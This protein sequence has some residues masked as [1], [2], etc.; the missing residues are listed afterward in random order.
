MVFDAAG[1]PHSAD[2]TP[3]GTYTVSGVPVGVVQVSVQ[4]PD[5]ALSVLP[6]QIAQRQKERQ[7]N[8]PVSRPRPPA[9]R[10]SWFLLPAVYSTPASSGLSTS[11]KSGP[12]S[13]DIDLK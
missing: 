8:P 10:D 7:F 4:S 12:N 13:F 5:P 2:I 3:E 11:L 6:P 1:T 9:N